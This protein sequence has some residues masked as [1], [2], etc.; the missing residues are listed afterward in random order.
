MVFMANRKYVF[1][2]FLLCCTVSI[3][4]MAQTPANPMSQALRGAWTSAKVNVRKSADVMPEAK[5]GFKP[6][7]GVR[8]FGALLAHVAGASYEFCAA[9]KGEKSPHSEDEFEKSAKTKA[10][11]VKALDG[12]IAYC[13]DVYKTLD[14]AKVA[15]V[16][17]GAFGGPASARAA[18]LIGNTTHFQEHYGNIVTYLRINGLVPPSSAPRQ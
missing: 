13:D 11:I 17:P 7:D 2:T 14:D 9:A 3:P 4:A 6:V 16:V 12:A 10:D 5:Y 8:T 15:Q 18:S 1:S